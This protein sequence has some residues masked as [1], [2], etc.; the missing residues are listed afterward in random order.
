MEERKSSVF[1]AFRTLRNFAVIS[2]MLGVYAVWGFGSG[3]CGLAL[4]R[5]FWVRV[6]VL[7]IALLVVCGFFAGSGFDVLG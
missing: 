7:M 4:L 5:G 3:M 1:T 6:Q 2:C